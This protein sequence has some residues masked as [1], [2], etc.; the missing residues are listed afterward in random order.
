M[1]AIFDKDVNGDVKSADI[2]GMALRG[3][4]ELASHRLNDWRLNIPGK[5]T[6]ILSKLGVTAEVSTTKPELTPCFK[7]SFLPQNSIK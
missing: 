2:C 1:F 3:K 4:C 6:S 7:C 5:P